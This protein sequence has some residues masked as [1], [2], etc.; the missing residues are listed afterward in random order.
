VS[1]PTHGQDVET[2]SQANKSGW[3]SWGMGNAPT[4]TQGLE[5]VG[6]TVRQLRNHSE[7][8]APVVVFEQTELA[9]AFSHLLE[10]KRTELGELVYHLKYG[11][12]KDG[13]RVIAAAASEFVRGRWGEGVDVVVPAPPSAARS[14]QPLIQIASELAD[15]LDL[16]LITNA[17][18]KTK[19][20]AQM[21]NVDAQDRDALLQEAIQKGPGNVVGRRVLL[22]DDVTESG[23]TLRRSAEVLLADAGALSVHALVITRTK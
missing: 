7:R 17:L 9:R 8:L 12:Q 1:G 3:V 19:A 18:S 5:P 20:T 23:A 13:A 21:K 10:T 16:P 22:I 11:G 2:Q 15:A 14:S 6:K 4:I